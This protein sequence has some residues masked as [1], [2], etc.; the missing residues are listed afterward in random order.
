[1]V[2]YYLMV[3]SSPPRNALKWQSQHI[4]NAKVIFK[5]AEE[6][7]RQ[8]PKELASLNSAVFKSNNPKV[9]CVPPS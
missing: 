1:M 5:T 3:L 8:R 7:E 2:N 6:H 4:M 9:L